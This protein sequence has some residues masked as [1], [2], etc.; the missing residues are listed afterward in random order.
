MLPTTKEVQEAF[1]GEVVKLGGAVNNAFDDGEV[2]L[3][4]A[5][6]PIR[7]EVKRRDVV[8]AGVALRTTSRQVYVHPYVFREVCRNGAIWAHATGEHSIPFVSFASSNEQ[9]EEVLEEICD[10]V[11]MCASAEAFRESLDDIRQAAA[12]RG[13]ADLLLNLLSSMPRGT[14]SPQ[15]LAEIV[16]R[17]SRDEE[18][19]AFGMMNAVTSVAR[20]TRD[21]H[22]KWRLEELG[23]AVPALV[24]PVRSP[25]RTGAVPEYCR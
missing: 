19:S 22:A 13:D 16:R 23:G 1:S 24:R 4:R 20:D 8:Q 25:G 11:H 10:T 15:I 21:A 3:L 18:D 17:F 9:V 12:V 7:A 6:V 5:T 2:L 14:M